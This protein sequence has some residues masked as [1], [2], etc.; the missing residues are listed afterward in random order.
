M[1]GYVMVA[2]L[3]VLA[4]ILLVYDAYGYGFNTKT[5]DII[6]NGLLF[7]ESK[8][9]G[10]SIYLNGQNQNNTT[11]ARL[12][13]PAGNYT[14]S[15]KKDGYR[16]WQR[17][18]TLTEHSIARYVYPFL[19]PTKPVTSSLKTYPSQPSLVIQSPD[20]RWLLVP[21]SSTDTNTVSFDELDTTNLAQASKSISIPSG[22][23][24]STNLPGSSLSVVEWSTD[25]VNV[26]L[27]HAYQGGNEFI[28]FNRQDPAKSYN[29]NK[30]FNVSPSQVA[31]R[32]KKVDQLYIY[33]Q[34]GGT[35][36]VGDTSKATLD[37]PILRNILAFKAYGSNLLAYVT[38][39][40]V[41]AGQVAARV[42]DNGKTY[43]LSS[44]AAG[45]VYLIDAT[46]FQGHWYYVAGSNTSDRVNVFKDPMDKLHSS[47]KATPLMALRQTGGTKVSFSANTRFV[48]VEAGQGFAVYDFETQSYYR[49]TL[50]TKIDGPLHWMDGH[51]LVGSSQGKIF[52]M[53][54]DS[55]NQQTLSPTLLPDGG[56]F[57]RD[58]NHLIT[59]APSSS[60]GKT[61]LQSID[62]RAGSE[63]PKNTLQN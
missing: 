8:P 51:R 5:G 21:S 41:P 40:G 42:W 23:L 47:S 34:S 13:L 46:Q 48:A 6:E 50:S 28:V 63:L 7:V 3:I 17:T 36:Q 25:N 22:L 61:I 1:V 37:T 27:A 44:F 43:L 11:S 18:F 31:L 26:L 52:I 54:Y 62:L 4:T 16:N 33:Q 38:S 24:T 32:N 2:I 14:L 59:V 35:L 58:Y 57:D 30:L 12:V 39:N 9:G 15:L 53:D 49:Y 19:F 55:V 45:N 60:P 20:R 29:V 56:Y 10:A